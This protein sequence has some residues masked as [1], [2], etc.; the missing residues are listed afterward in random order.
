MGTSA[1]VSHNDIHCL[2]LYYFPFFILVPCVAMDDPS[3]TAM[4]RTSKKKINK[5]F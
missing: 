3:S 2:A 1:S 5:I 4:Q